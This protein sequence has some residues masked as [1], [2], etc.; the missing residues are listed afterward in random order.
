M[1]SQHR[2]L[3]EL[4]DILMMRLTC[5]ECG[6]AISV[7]PQALK[8]I[9]NACQNCSTDWFLNNDPDIKILRSLINSLATLQK[10]GNETPCHI[11]F[12]VEQ[13]I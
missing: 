6:S 9:Y 4:Q 10:R 12:E 3:L 13:Q 8:T 11:Q 5:R 7:A 2:S 1:T